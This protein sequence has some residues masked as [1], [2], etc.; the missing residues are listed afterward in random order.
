[1]GETKQKNHPLEGQYIIYKYG[2]QDSMDERWALA[3][4]QLKKGKMK[5]V[6][7]PR[8]HVMEACV[9]GEE[10]I[11]ELLQLMEKRGIK[12]V[13]SVFHMDD[14]FGIPANWFSLE[15]TTRGK[16]VEEWAEYESLYRDDEETNLL[17][18]RGI[19]V[20]FYKEPRKAR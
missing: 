7:N 4:F 16:E 13:Y 6:Y 1:M 17:K 9:M 20:E 3:L 10:N 19:A 12:K 15:H 2:E 11:E 14:F 8:D 5:E 18:E